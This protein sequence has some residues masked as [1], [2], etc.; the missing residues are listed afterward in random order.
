MP[1]GGGRN[2]EAATEP[3]S[4]AVARGNGGFKRSWVDLQEACGLAY[5][6][7]IQRLPIKPASGFIGGSKGQIPSG[8]NVTS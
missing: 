4:W 2:L 6:K 3:D 1:K 5:G 7:Q 8:S